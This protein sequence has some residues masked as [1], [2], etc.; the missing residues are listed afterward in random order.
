LKKTDDENPDPVY[1][2][3]PYSTELIPKSKNEGTT[4]ELN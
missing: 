2:D 1:L 4:N 3:L